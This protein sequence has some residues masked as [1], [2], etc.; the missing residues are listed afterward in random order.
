M[1]KVWPELR[2]QLRQKVRVREINSRVTVCLHSVKP[3]CYEQRG[4]SYHLPALPK[5]WAL[6]RRSLRFLAL[7]CTFLTAA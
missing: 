5:K 6:E 3:V 4:A 2:V 7:A 1:E